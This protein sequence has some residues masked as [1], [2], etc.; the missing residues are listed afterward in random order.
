M[1]STGNLKQR[2]KRAESQSSLSHRLPTS[3]PGQQAELENLWFLDQFFHR[4]SEA[5]HTYLKGGLCGLTHVPP[6]DLRCHVP[7]RKDLRC[8]GCDFCINSSIIA[9]PFSLVCRYHMMSSSQ[10]GSQRTKQV[11]QTQ[12]TTTLI[13]QWHHHPVFNTHN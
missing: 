7:G 5:S 4:R 13:T 2:L 9:L 6:S 3:S 12:F 10:K 1:W 8:S 11:T